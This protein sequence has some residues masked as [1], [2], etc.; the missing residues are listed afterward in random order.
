M[1]RNRIIA[2]L[3][4]GTMLLSLTACGSSAKIAVKPATTTAAAAGGGGN[5]ADQTATT[6]SGD[7]SN[8]S[9][10]PLPADASADCKKLYTKFAGQ[11]GKFGG[12]SSSDPAKGLAALGAVFKSIR[13]DVPADLRDDVDL[14][15]NA[16]QKY[17]DA[18]SKA[19]GDPTKAMSDPAVMAA[20]TDLSDPKYEAASKALS[21]YFDKTCPELAGSND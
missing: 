9:L 1:I 4:A 6:V 2:G 19:G 13:D 3:A 21:D 14:M 12:A 17:G 8:D 5:S 18:L 15:A 10:P 16:Y 11:Y 7:N 20:I